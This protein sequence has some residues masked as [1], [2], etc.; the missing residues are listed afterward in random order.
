MDESR[1]EPVPR[2]AVASL[3]DSILDRIPDESAT[4]EWRSA[5]RDMEIDDARDEDL[6]GFFACVL[7]LKAVSEGNAGIGCVLVAGDGAVVAYGHNQVFHP[8]FRSDLHGEMVTMDAFEDK[9]L[10]VAPRELT[11]YSSLEPCP[12]CMVRLVTAG[13]GRVL[14]IARDESWGMTEERH[15]L[16]PIWK[17]LAEGKVF[18]GAECSPELRDIAFDIFSINI[19]A[20]YEALKNR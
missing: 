14:Y 7:A 10:D 4:T 12:M 19:D 5:L 6:Y 8:Y 9:R 15:K 17:D 16:P 13:I 2:E 1:A 11:L 18:A 20:L 3:A